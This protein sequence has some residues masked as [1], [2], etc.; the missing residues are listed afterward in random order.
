MLSGG[1]EVAA[2]LTCRRAQGSVMS[3][4]H[5]SA[6]LGSLGFSSARSFLPPVTACAGLMSPGSVP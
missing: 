5:N 3:P 6:V 2:A 1:G 4:L